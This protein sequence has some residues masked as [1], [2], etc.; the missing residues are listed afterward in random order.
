MMFGKT[1]F[2]V[3]TNKKGDQ[4]ASHSSKGLLHSSKNLMNESD[5]LTAELFIKR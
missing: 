5:N 3:I 4:I 1:S 2:Y